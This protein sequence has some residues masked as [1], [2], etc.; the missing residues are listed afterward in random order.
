MQKETIFKKLHKFFAENLSNWNKIDHRKFWP[1]AIFIVNLL[2]DTINLLIVFKSFE[3][4]KNNFFKEETLSQGPDWSFYDQNQKLNPLL[5][6]W[7][8]CWLGK[9][10]KEFIYQNLSKYV[11][12]TQHKLMRLGKDR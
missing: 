10:K 5:N 2:L 9:R 6:F 3:S 11:K 1:S 8:F 4:L 12:L 7:L